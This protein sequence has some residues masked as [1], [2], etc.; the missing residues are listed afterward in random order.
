MLEKSRAQILENFRGRK[1]LIGAINEIIGADFKIVSGTAAAA[2]ILSYGD[3]NKTVVELGK[4][5]LPGAEKIP[6]L[7]GVCGADP[8]RAMEN[9]LSQLKALGF[10]GVANFPTVGVIDGKFRAALEESGLGYGQEVE[11][12]RTARRL[13]LLTCAF[14]F[15]AKQAADMAKAGAD[16]LVARNFDASTVSREIFVAEI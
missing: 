3:A 1:R 8:F 12:I 16:I 4:K 5:I 11:M 7:A 13:D 10:N 6:M 9:F 2:G 15:D 14:V